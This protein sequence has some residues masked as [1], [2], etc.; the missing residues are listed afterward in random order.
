MV[1]KNAIKE[2]KLVVNLSEIQVLHCKKKHNIFEEWT[3]YEGGLDEENKSS[4][5]VN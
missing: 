1:F 4:V 3:E 2:G 5:L